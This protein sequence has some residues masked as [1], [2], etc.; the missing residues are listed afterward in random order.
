M[1]T[2]RQLTAVKMPVVLF[3]ALV[4]A[5][6]L[7]VACANE[8]IA[9]PM[10]DNPPTGRSAGCYVDVYENNDFKGLFTR[11]WGPGTYETL[12]FNGKNY[13]NIISSAIAGPKAYVRFNDGDQRENHSIWLMPNERMS[14]MGKVNFNDRTKLIE[15]LDHAPTKAPTTP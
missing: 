5:L 6:A 9:R 2:L 1:R 12:T 10:D 15:I 8:P 11:I 4:C 13:S 7:L 3:S 14:D